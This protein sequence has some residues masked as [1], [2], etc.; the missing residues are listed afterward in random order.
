MDIGRIS[1][2]VPNE[3]GASV[4]ENGVNFALYS[5]SATKVILNLFE[6]V[7]S[8]EPSDVIGFNPKT[9]K[10]GDVWH[11]FVQGLKPGALYLYQLDGPYNPPVG[12]RFNSNK[13]I[14]DPCAKALSSGSLFCL[15]NKQRLDGRAGIENG[16]LQDLSDFQKCVV[17]DDKDFDWQGDKPLNRPLSETI[18]YEMHVRGFTQS[19]TSGVEHPGTYKGIIEKIP[20]LKFL[21]ITAVELMPVFEFD[22]NETEFV[23]PKTGKT[24][25]NYWG[26]SPASF[27]APEI[28][29]ASNKN[30]G[31][32][33]YEFKE[34]VRELHKAGIEVIL[35]VVYNHTAEGNEYGKTFLYRGIE[36][37]VYYILSTGCNQYYDNYTGCGNT[38]NAN[39][40]V[41]MSHIIQSLK[42]WVLDMHVDGFRFDLASALCR[43]KNGSLMGEPPLPLAISE[44]PVLA[45]TKIIAE[46]WDCAGGYH[47]G[48]FPGRRWCEWNGRFRDDIRR[49]IRG[50]EH[51]AKDAATRMAGSSDLYSASGRQPFHS[52]NFVTAHDGF[53][54]NDLVSYNY[55]HNEENGEENRDGSDNN[56]SYNNG[57]EGESTNPSIIISRKRKIKNFFACLLLSQGT[58]MILAG[59]EMQRSQGGNNNAYCQDNEISWINWHDCDKNADILRYTRLLIALRK[60]HAVFRRDSYFKD[61]SEIMW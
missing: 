53:T 33:V 7:S 28:S 21:G 54:L 14:L 5:K 46:P 24:L 60:K 17:V 48:N 51:C 6:S 23:N 27:F 20:Y 49:F 12:Q 30:A 10:T 47:L 55:K 57:Y 2:G 61:T 32:V 41:T 1:E 44:D 52:I 34:M 38:V 35:D 37:A 39:H 45:N 36:N 16:K 11:I 22:E 26:Y 3:L 40:P 58:P 4:F 56:L 59:D 43:G 15:Y 31:S 29:Y 18:I 8:T 19:S 50:D 9:N 42:H 25:T 13:Y